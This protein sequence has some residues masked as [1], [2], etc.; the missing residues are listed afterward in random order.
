MAAKAPCARLMTRIRPMVTTRPNAIRHRTKPYESPYS[1]MK[2]MEFTRA[3]RV[4]WV[5]RYRAN[6]L[7]ASLQR[8]WL[9][10]LP[11]LCDLIT[12]NT[13]AGLDHLSQVEVLHQFTGGRGGP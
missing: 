6:R 7:A 3:G 10:L 4:R 8:S 11:H 12:L 9:D 5:R 2:A 1:R 13:V